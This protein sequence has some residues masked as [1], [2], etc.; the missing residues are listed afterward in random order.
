MMQG[1]LVVLATLWVTAV[2]GRNL[3]ELHAG[4][5]A[6]AGGW[7]FT[8]PSKGVD[9]SLETAKLTAILTAI[10]Y[11][12]GGDV[13]KWQCSKCDKRLKKPDVIMNTMNNLVFLTDNGIDTIYVVFRGTDAVNIG[14]WISNLDFFR[15]DVPDICAKCKVHEGIYRMYGKL[16]PLLDAPLATRLASLPGARLYITGHSLGGAF[17]NVLALYVKQKYG[18]DPVVYSFGS[19]RLGNDEFAAFYNNV[20]P[21]SYRVNNFRDIVPHV[22]FKAMG[23]HHAGKLQFCEQGTNCR[24]MYTHESDDGFLHTSVVDHLYYLGL[25][26]FDYFSMWFQVGCID[27]W[28]AGNYTLPPYPTDPELISKVPGLAAMLARAD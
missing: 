17:A 8:A 6:S 13:A 2:H 9:W 23:F 14:Q 12:P 21:S 28:S 19:P 10:A 5:V 25:N 15:T 16:F 18:I 27:P 20:I 24:A 7:N 4:G 1:V 22:P 26:M 11:C 3:F